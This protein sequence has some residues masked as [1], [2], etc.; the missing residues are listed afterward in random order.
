[1]ARAMPLNVR[2]T[3]AQVRRRSGST[4][5]PRRRPGPEPDD[6]QRALLAELERGLEFWQSAGSYE[7][8]R[9]QEPP[10]L[11]RSAGA[12]LARR[13]PHDAHAQWTP[14]KNRPSPVDVVEAGNAGRVAELVPLRMGRMAASPFVFLRG[15]ASV[16]AW[17][18]SHTPVSGPEVITATPISTIS[19]GSAH[20]S[21]RSSST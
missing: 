2:A 10:D 3:P 16:M 18:L 14:P 7:A 20:R 13:V 17:D 6:T 4:Q 11:R 19:A 5:R 21:E 1:M 8:E 9:H 15:A 12:E